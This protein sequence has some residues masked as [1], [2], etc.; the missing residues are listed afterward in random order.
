MRP[1][2][3]EM[4]SVEPIYD[5]GPAFPSHGT[6]GEIVQSGMTLRDYFAAKAPAQPW[7]FYQPTMPPRPTLGVA[8]S[9]DGQRKYL[10]AIDAERKEGDCWSWSNRNAVDEWDAENKRQYYIQ[11]P[12]FYADAMLAERMK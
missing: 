7:P 6:M 5:G 11:W 4:A 1:E 9:D 12:Y 2:D 8:V 10:T 3:R